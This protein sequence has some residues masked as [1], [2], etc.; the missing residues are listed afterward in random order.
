[1]ANSDPRLLTFF[2]EWAREYFSPDAD[3][4]LAL[5]IHADN[6]LAGA[7]RFWT[8]ALPLHDPKFTK[9]FIKP[10][11]TGH[12]KNHLAHG[13]CRVR[14]RRSTDAWVQAM[15]WIDEIA[16]GGWFDRAATLSGGR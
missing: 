1:M 5:N 6:D 8:D 14:M 7:K 3:F 9:A 13:V 2:I 4:V 16:H 12:R 10:D 11:G 15:A